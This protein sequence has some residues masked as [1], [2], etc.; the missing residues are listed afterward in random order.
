M[1]LIIAGPEM[2]QEN[3]FLRSLDIVEPHIGIITEGSSPPVNYSAP[4]S[5]KGILS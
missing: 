4:R 2:N 5:L 3:V 1:R